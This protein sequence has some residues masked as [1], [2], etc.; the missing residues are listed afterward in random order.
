MKH[1]ISA[2]YICFGLL[3]VTLIYSKNFSGPILLLYLGWILV[4]VGIFYSYHSQIINYFKY[5]SEDE[6][7]DI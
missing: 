6:K 1:L 3:I 5:D 2:L 4:I 7:K